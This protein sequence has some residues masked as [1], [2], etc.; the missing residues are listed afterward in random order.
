MKHGSLRLIGMCVVAVLVMGVGAA[1]AAPAAEMSAR[2][3]PIVG[4]EFQIGVGGSLGPDV[5]FRPGGDYFAVWE[6]SNWQSPWGEIVGQR[7]TPAGALAGAEVPVALGPANATWPQVAYNSKA[8]Y[9]LAVWV[10]TR[11]PGKPAVFG[12]RISATGAPIGSDF[13]ISG[14]TALLTIYDWPALAYNSATNQFL[15]VWADLRSNSTHGHDVYGRRVSASGTTVGSDFLISGP[16]ADEDDDS[17]AVAYSPVANQFLVV[18]SDR[19]DLY[20]RNSDIYGRRVKAFGA[21][22]KTDFRITNAAGLR[23][24][25]SPTIAYNSDDDQFLVAWMDERNGLYDIYGQRLPSVGAKIGGN[26]RISRGPDHEA[27]PSAAYSPDAGQYLVVWD[28]GRN[29]PTR[30]SD[31]YGRRVTADGTLLDKDFRICAAADK[32]S[33]RMPDVAYGNGEYLVAWSNFGTDW[34]IRGVR[35]DAAASG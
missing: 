20:T 10:D 25:G 33:D 12:L 35:L 3:W 11:N 5:A 8:G 23:G 14:P 15:V 21:V 1:A 22:A 27:G 30:G 13:Q 7:V 26:F 9:F 24:E 2:A 17:P 32:G 6:K 16:N 34:A 28:D 31:V 19:R 4:S 29:S 18:W